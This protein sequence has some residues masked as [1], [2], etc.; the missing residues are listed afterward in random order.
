[1]TSSRRHIDPLLLMTLGGVL[2]G[3]TGFALW[4]TTNTF[5]FLPVFLA[6]GLVTGISIAESRRQS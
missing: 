1:M 2:G 4:M 3:L 5:V 6:I